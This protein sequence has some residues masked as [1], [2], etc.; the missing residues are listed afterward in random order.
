[1]VT[2]KRME[3]E[4]GYNEAGQWHLA[5]KYMTMHLVTKAG[6]Y[7]NHSSIMAQT[8]LRFLACL[9]QASSIET[10]GSVVTVDNNQ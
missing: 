5:C 9:S 7:A 10:A 6:K 3:V 1:M 4:V 8:A 2:R